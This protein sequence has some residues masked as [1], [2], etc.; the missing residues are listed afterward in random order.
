MIKVL[1]TTNSS[2]DKFNSFN[3]TNKLDLTSQNL[4]ETFKSNI[5][6]VDANVFNRLSEDFINENELYVYDSKKLAKTSSNDKVKFI[7][8]VE[9]LIDFLQLWA[10]NFKVIWLLGDIK[11][12]TG[13]FRRAEHMYIIEDGNF[14]GENVFLEFK[15]SNYQKLGF[16]NVGKYKVYHYLKATKTNV[17]C[18]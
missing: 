6:L 18:D 15:L 1:I 11:F 2:F 10:S 13:W 5:F 17:K 4:K 12:V 3:F 7:T 16:Q 14:E 9:D 8:K